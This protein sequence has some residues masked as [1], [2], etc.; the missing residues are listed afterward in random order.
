MDTP[1]GTQSRNG[2]EEVLAVYRGQF[3]LEPGALDFA[4]NPI[5]LEFSRN[6]LKTP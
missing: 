5:D 2:I 4:R 6:P 1:A 3:G